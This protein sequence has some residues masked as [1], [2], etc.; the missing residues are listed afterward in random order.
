MQI[1]CGCYKEMCW[2]KY[3]EYCRDNMIN[4]Y[5]LKHQEEL[6]DFASY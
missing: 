4:Y 1:N 2:G 6:S 5:S 3:L